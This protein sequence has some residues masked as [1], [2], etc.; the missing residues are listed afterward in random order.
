MT[1]S[2]REPAVQPQALPY[3]VLGDRVYVWVTEKLEVHFDVADF[4][5]YRATLEPKGYVFEEQTD[6]VAG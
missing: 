6:H 2:T 3:R 4:A 1:H 5:R